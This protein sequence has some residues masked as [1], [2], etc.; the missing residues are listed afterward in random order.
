MICDQR[1]FYF[2]LL[3]IEIVITSRHSIHTKQ[4]NLTTKHQHSYTKALSCYKPLFLATYPDRGHIHAYLFSKRKK[5][6]CLFYFK[7]S[8]FACLKYLHTYLNT[9]TISWRIITYLGKT[10]KE[11]RRNS[12]TSSQY[13]FEVSYII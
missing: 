3:L 6:E 10:I 2:K 4:H 1:N 9:S 11:N 8:K 7:S 12:I 13:G 5:R